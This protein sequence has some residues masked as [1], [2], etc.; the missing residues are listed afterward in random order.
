MFV[1]WI[2]NTCTILGPDT[3]NFE[4]G[5][6]GEFGECEGHCGEMGERIRHR[7]CIHPSNGGYPCPAD[8]DSEL[9]ACEMAPC[10]GNAIMRLTIVVIL[11][12]YIIIF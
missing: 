2:R 9:E 4:W 5:P 7:P 8:V 12:P 6:W 3:K 1:I 11:N 10:P